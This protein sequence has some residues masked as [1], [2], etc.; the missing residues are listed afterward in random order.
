M[1]TLPCTICEALH[2]TKSRINVHTVGFGIVMYACEVAEPRMR[3]KQGD[4]RE[5]CFALNV[6]QL[7]YLL[8]PG[9]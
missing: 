6:S 7:I 4:M 8:P 2:N 9:V 5:T 3:L 1:L